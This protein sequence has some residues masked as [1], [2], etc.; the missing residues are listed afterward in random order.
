MHLIGEEHVQSV[1]TRTKKQLSA[2]HLTT[3]SL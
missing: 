3:M 2:N 1:L